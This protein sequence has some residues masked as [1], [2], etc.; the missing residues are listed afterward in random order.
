MHSISQVIKQRFGST[1]DYKALTVCPGEH[2]A[3][4]K[5]TRTHLHHIIYL[6]AEKDQN[7]KF[8]E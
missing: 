6:Y 5:F 7:T 4:L 1:V 3:T 2:V 8:E